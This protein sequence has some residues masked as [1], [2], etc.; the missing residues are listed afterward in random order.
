MV[1][2]S[3]RNKLNKIEYRRKIRTIEREKERDRERQRESECESERE[4]LVLEREGN[5]GRVH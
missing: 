5:N 2:V 3:K 4:K 1:R